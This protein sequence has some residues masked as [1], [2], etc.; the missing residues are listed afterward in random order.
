[1]SGVKD[2][3]LVLLS[4]CRLLLTQS[5]EQHPMTAGKLIELLA[6]EGYHTERKTIYRHIEALCSFGLDVLH[7][8]D[9]PRG[10][11]VVSRDFDLTELRLLIDAV[12]SSYFITHKKSAE[13]IDKLAALASVHEAERLK[14]GL[15]LDTVSKT[16][17]EKTYYYIDAIYKAIATDM[18]VEFKYLEFTPTGEKH[19]R[20]GGQKYVVSPY[21]V[22]CEGGRYYLHAYHEKYDTISS[23]RIDLMESVSVSK[24]KRLKSDEYADYDPVVRGKTSFDQF[25]GTLVRVVARFDNSLAGALISR[26]G[27]DVKMETSGDGHFTAAFDAELSPRFFAWVFGFGGKARL[28]S[29]KAAVTRYVNELERVRALYGE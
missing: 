16:D 25:G 28:L 7:S 4:L 18:R 14:K 9:A 21:A 29:P 15:H 27:D 6:A 12:E 22:V 19:Y 3:K 13:L 8:E 11:Y 26:F 24:L 2:S 17:N 20:Q 10:Y 23:F 5:D 1:M